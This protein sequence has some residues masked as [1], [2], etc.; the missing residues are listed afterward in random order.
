M[1]RRRA[2]RIVILPLG[3]VAAA[4][5]PPDPIFTSKFRA[6]R[7]RGILV[8]VA[9]GNEGGAL[10]RP[11]NCPPALAV[12][13]TDLEDTLVD[14]SSRGPQIAM[15]APGVDIIVM[16]LGGGYQKNSGTAYSVTI[17]AS[18]AALVLSTR[19]DLSADDVESILRQ[20]AKKLDLG[21]ELAGAGRV[22]ALAAVRLAKTYKSSKQ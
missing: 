16:S 6:L 7:E 19:P 13:A 2:Q 8:F 18:I 20:S 1:L 5:A 9:A 21:A 4:G 3:W 14:F 12:A 22:D 10:R 17:A 11:A 15:A